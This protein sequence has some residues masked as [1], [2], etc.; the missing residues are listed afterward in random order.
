[1]ALEGSFYHRVIEKITH[2]A[3]HCF[4]QQHDIFLR[5]DEKKSAKRDTSIYTVTFTCSMDIPCWHAI[6]E[7]KDWGEPFQP[8]DFHPHWHFLRPPLGTERY[9]YDPLILDSVV[10][11]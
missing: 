3:L 7:C 1:M 9:V 6:R 10:R 8:F 2:Y 5:D 4:K 11:Q